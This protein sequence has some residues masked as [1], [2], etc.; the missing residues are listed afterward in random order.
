MVRVTSFNDFLIE[1]ASLSGTLVGGIKQLEVELE[2]ALGKLSRFDG[3]A[4]YQRLSTSAGAAIGITYF[5][6]DAEQT[7]QLVYGTSKRLGH[8]SIIG[9]RVWNGNWIEG[10]TGEPRQPDHTIDPGDWDL[11][12][13]EHSSV[14]AKSIASAI[15]NNHVGK[16]S[17]L[18]PE[19]FLRE[20]LQNTSDFRMLYDLYCQDKE[21]DDA[22]VV[23]FNEFKAIVN[24]HGYNCP[25]Q[26]NPVKNPAARV[27]RAKVSLLKVL[28][29]ATVI[30]ARGNGQLGAVT[31]VGYKSMVASWRSAGISTEQIVKDLDDDLRGL[32][33]VVA[34]GN[35]NSL[36]VAGRGG[37][38]K[39]FSVEDELGHE[40]A[41]KT[42]ISLA[43]KTSTYKLFETFF[44]NRKRGKIVVLDDINAFD[45]ES[46][47]LLK[48]ALDS[49][50]KRVITWSSK[51][52]TP[53][54]RDFEGTQS[55]WLDQVEESYWEA[56][57]DG[58]AALAKFKLP[59]QV[60]FEAAVIF[61]TNVPMSKLYDD[62]H[63]GAVCSRSLKLDYDLNDDEVLTKIEMMAKHIR[64]DVSDEVKKEVLEVLR[65]NLKSGL[66]TDLSM[67][68]FVNGIGIAA[69]GLPASRWKR[70]LGYS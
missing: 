41:G 39:T 4:G 9:I 22:D 12:D 16:I 60:L 25:A 20:N 51:A 62:P 17:V 53:M 6:Q 57:A 5:R 49:K 10:S 11:L 52:T 67:R 15:A 47:N 13:K 30:S 45:A 58:P 2:N 8:A 31:D 21:V 59:N 36:V 27:S 26:F 3:P 56:V 18:I 69:S 68:Q 50:P 66:L 32:V 43:G 34:T 44:L 64:K 29:S 23:D 1:A 42:W 40:N 14:I 19:G 28:E 24:N 63:L 33:K 48:A 46:A 70:L 61:I 37:V 55:E 38:G 35:A 65:T 54:P 7:I